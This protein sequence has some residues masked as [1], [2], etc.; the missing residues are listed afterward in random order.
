MPPNETSLVMASS[1][2]VWIQNHGAGTGARGLAVRS[3]DR[4]EPSYDALERAHERG[5]RLLRL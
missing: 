5:R 3:M 2:L 1:S 4:A